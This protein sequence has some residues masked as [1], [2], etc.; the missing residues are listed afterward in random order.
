MF[1]KKTAFSLAE[2]MVVLLILSIILAASMPVITK[3]SRVAAAVQKE[4]SIPAGVINSYAGINAPEGWLLCAG[5]A[6]SR[7]TY[8]NLYS[9]IGTTFGAGNGI[10]TFNLPD[11]RGRAPVGLDNIGGISA[12]RITAAVADVLGGA[13]G[14]E[15]HTLTVSEMPAHSHTGYT[16]SQGAHQHTFSLNR[17]WSGKGWPDGYG[18]GY[19]WYDIINATQYS[20]NTLYTNIDGAHSHNIYTYGVGGGTTH[21]NMQPYI[22]LNYIIKY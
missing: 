2:M 8:S 21:N 4:N 20:S 6:I 1:R 16:D 5:Q 13:G 11:L 7:S 18:F 17:Q 22:A 3:R 15:I 10:T 9:A 14:E 12:N 19:G